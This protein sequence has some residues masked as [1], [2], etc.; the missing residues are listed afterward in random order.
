MNQNT[1]LILC[2]RTHLILKMH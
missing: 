1:N 2:T